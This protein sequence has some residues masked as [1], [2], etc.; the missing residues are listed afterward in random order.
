L[1][2]QVLEQLIVEKIQLQEAQQS[3][4][5][6]SDAELDKIIADIAAR[7]KLSMANFREAIVKSGSTFSSYRDLLR[8]DVIVT[9]FREREVDA[10]IKISDAE[11]DNY[12]SERAR[13]MSATAS[14]R[15]STAA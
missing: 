11:V 13:A 9:R 2:K 14:A 6:V 5:S 4:I 12:I 8:N 10:Q 7:N 1:R 15:A 3:G